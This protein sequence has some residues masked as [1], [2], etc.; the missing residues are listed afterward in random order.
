M[1][2]LVET[3]EATDTAALPLN[4]GQRMG[5]ALEILAKAGNPIVGEGGPS[6]RQQPDALDAYA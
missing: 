6:G 2:N 5:R 4:C 1:E 3:H